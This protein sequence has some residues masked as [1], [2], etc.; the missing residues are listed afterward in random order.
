M[1]TKILSFPISAVL[2]QVEPLDLE[3]SLENAATRMHHYRSLVL[4]VVSELGSLIGILSDTDILK[5][6][7]GGVSLDSSVKRIMWRDPLTIRTSGTCGQALDLL[8]T[9]ENTEGTVLVV[10]DEQNY[11]LGIVSALDIITCNSSELRPNTVGGMATP[12]GVYLTDGAMSAGVPS[13]TLIVTGALLFGS[14]MVTSSL[15]TYL[16][17]QAV[18]AHY[19]PIGATYCTSALGLFL[20]LVLIRLSPLSGMHAAEHMV[21][22]AIERGER[23]VPELVSKMPRVH[24]RCGTNLAVAIGLFLGIANLGLFSDPE[25][26]LIVT[27]VVTLILWRPL[28]NLLQLFLTTKP[29]SSK[30]IEGGILAGKE[31][32]EKYQNSPVYSPSVISKLI[33]SGIF[34][35]ILGSVVTY[36]LIELIFTLLNVPKLY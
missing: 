15:A 9:K 24:P 27:L 18:L 6:I 7:E 16:I 31:L 28:G 2:Q 32:I 29:P 11:P 10:I 25:I 3:I 35:I 30:Q 1:D 20:F 22:H 33:H 36:F 34:H 23:L 8:L 17:E 21:V 14:L 13:Y 5:A 19:L 4:P 26:N 12:F